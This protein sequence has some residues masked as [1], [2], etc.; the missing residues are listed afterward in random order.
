VIA[1]HIKKEL[2]NKNQQGFINEK[3]NH[4]NEYNK[5]LT[6]YLN[7]NNEVSKR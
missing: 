4:S 1:K 2:K 3:N 7:K 6:T 5:E